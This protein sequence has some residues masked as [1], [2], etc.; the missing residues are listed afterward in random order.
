[1]LLFFANI[2]AY[3]RIIVYYQRAKSA[4]A[5]RVHYYT[6]LLSPCLAKSDK[7]YQLTPTQ[8][9]QERK[10]HWPRHDCNYE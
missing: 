7:P 6:E 10:K 9:H 2:A 8:F 4:A 1:M 3:A 5:E